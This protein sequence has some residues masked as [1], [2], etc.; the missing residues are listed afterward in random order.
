MEELGAYAQG[1][2]RAHKKKVR[3][4]PYGAQ[5]SA[6]SKALERVPEIKI[7]LKEEEIAE[8][9]MKGKRPV[10]PAYVSKGFQLCGKR[11]STFLIG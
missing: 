8:K 2:K 1:M 6:T 11:R 10:K 3:K 4:A 5:A 9:E 7:L